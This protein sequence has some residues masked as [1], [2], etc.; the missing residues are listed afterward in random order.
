MCREKQQKLWDDSKASMAQSSTSMRTTRLSLG[1]T[2]DFQSSTES[3]SRPKVVH[4]EPAATCCLSCARLE[5]GY[6]VVV[7]V[8]FFIVGVKVAG[9]VPREVV[10][11]VA[12]VVATAVLG[13]A[14]GFVVVVVAESLLGQDL[15]RQ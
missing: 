7:V 5:A 12:E 6:V 2:L 3:L 10:A 8:V 14:V 1:S 11:E 13:A 9:V 15:R 4:A